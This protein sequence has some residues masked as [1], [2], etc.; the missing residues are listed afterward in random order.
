MRTFK[1]TCFKRFLLFLAAISLSAMI[2][3]SS[4]TRACWE[5]DILY[6]FK[7]TCFKRFLLFL[8]AISLSAMISSSSVTRACWE[9]D[10]L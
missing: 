6:T 8:A 4:V 10:I 5:L 3:S 7:V 1:V 2:S 9:E